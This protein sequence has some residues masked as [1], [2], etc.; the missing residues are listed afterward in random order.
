MICMRL[1]CARTC[2]LPGTDAG[3]VYAAVGRLIEI[4]ATDDDVIFVGG[5]DPDGVVVVALLTHVFRRGQ[6]IP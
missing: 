5:I 6:D 3:E 1:Y 2:Y 4:E